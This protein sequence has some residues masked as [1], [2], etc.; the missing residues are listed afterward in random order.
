MKTL[1]DRFY[2][3]VT[4]TRKGKQYRFN[5]INMVKPTSLYNEG[6]RPLCYS[7]KNSRA[8]GIG[9]IRTGYNCAYYQNGISKR[10]GTY[11]TLTFLIEFSNDFDEVYIAQ[12][13]PYTYSDL[14][15][16]L[17]DVHF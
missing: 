9:W 6:M 2:F 10:R 8:K 11:Y 7:M 14:Q 17:A 3:K 13:Y 5:L 16:D 15:W 12:C 1:H 4:N